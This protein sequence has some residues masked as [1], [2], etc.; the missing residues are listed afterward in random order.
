MRKRI[1]LGAAALLVGAAGL[2]LAVPSAGAT[3][4]GR[5][6][7]HALFDES[8]GD[9]SVFCRG[10]GPFTV[11]LAFRALNGDEVLHVAFQDGDFVE[12]PIPDGTSFSLQQAAGD[13]AGVDRKLV[14]TSTGAGDLVGWMSA[15]R[16]AGTGTRV[17]CETEP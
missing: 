4:A 13:T 16:L 6:A 1:A 5:P 14:V 17:R 2:Y 8:S 3:G 11:Y 10:D 9:T 12:Y 7:D 15:S